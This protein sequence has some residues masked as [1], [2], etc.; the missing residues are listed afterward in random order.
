MKHLRLFESFE[1]IN[2][3]CSEYDIKNYT[4]NSDGTVDVDG[5][6]NLRHKGLSKL[7]LKFGIVNGYFDCS[8]NQLTSLEGSPKEVHYNFF[9]VGNQLTTLEGGPSYVGRN[10]D[11]TGNLLTTLKGYL[12]KTGLLH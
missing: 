4:I 8:Y 2:S 12:L 6:V 3:I 1:G 11:C 5:G 10:F 9:C 7:P